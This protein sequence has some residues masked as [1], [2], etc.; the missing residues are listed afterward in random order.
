MSVGIRSGLEDAPVQVVEFADFQCPYCAHF[1]LTVL[2]VR[3]RYPDQVA[4]TFVPFP[5]KYHEYA[6]AAQRAAECAHIQGKFEA[7]R[8][9]LF[10][11]HHAFGSILWTDFAVQVGIEDINQFDAC[12]ND[13]EPLERIERGK[14][15][16]DK[17][18]VQ[19]TPTILINGWK[20]SAPPSA[21]SFDKIV[22]NVIN[23]RPPATD[24]DFL[25][26]SARN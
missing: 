24:I 25:G 16:A 14:K 8:S 5:L 22:K 15:L 19:G 12:V 20:V 6:E 2:A 11:K 18:G 4:F 21:E 7:I 9:I 10:E 26:S 13:T 17:F 3:N 23:G 1:E